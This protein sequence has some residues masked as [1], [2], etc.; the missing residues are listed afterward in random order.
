[1]S[2][3]PPPLIFAPARRIAAR[4]RALRLQQRPD[5]ARYLLDD[6][7][8]DVLERLARCQSVLGIDHPGDIDVDGGLQVSILRYLLE[9]AGESL[10]LLNDYPF[11]KGEAL[12]QR[13]AKQRGAKGFGAAPPP[14]RRPVAHRDAKQGE[15][16]ALR[17]LNMLERA[18]NDVRVAIDVKAALHAVSETAR[19]YGALLLEEGAVTDAKAA[20]TLGVSQADLTAAADELDRALRRR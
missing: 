10:V 1:M 15:V 5:A 9:R 19:T 12:L 16:R 18:V 8:E 4:R 6:M 3:D 13:L 2:G 17:V 14:K 11:E 20:K 7:V